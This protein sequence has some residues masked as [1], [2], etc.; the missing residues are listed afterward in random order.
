MRA[1]GYGPPQI[2]LHITVPFAEYK[3]AYPHLL[4]G[5][6]GLYFALLTLPQS[7]AKAQENAARCGAALLWT[8]WTGVWPSKK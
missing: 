6:P 8:W 5:W 1:E 3:A 2:L 4:G 7:Q